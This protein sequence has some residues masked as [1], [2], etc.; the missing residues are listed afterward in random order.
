MSMFTFS[1]QLKYVLITRYVSYTHDFWR[2]MMTTIVDCFCIL[3][4]V[5]QCGGS[6]LQGTEFPILT[7]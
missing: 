4:V 3:E 7:G 2:R 5:Y 6:W 1:V